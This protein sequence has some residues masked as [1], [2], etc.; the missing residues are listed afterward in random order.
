MRSGKQLLHFWIIPYKQRIISGILTGKVTNVRYQSLKYWLSAIANEVHIGLACFHATEYLWSIVKHCW[1]TG[2]LV[3]VTPNCKT[4]KNLLEAIGKVEEL[5]LVLDEIKQC[6][7]SDGVNLKV[8][9]C[10]C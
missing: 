8:Y 10:V 1:R 9:M 3:I 6:L 5:Q 4:W 7:Q 2:C